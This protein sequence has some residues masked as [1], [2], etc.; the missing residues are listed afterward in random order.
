MNKLRTKCDIE[1]KYREETTGS[2]SLLRNPLQGKSITR[3]YYSGVKWRKCC[4][5]ASHAATQP[6]IE[7]TSS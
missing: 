6:I 3:F 5:V 7:H 4:T 1:M 2:L